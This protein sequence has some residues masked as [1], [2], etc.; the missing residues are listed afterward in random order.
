L[1]A[2]LTMLKSICKIVNIDDMYYHDRGKG[3]TRP[4]V[5]E[6][7]PHRQNPNCLDSN[8]NL[9]LGL[10]WGLT[11][12]LIDGRNVTLTSTNSETDEFLVRSEFS[13]AIA[14]QGSLVVSGHEEL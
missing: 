4:L 7:A 1:S 6:G 5:R 9:V 12:R 10:R 3:Q 2:L 13:P 11:P 14:I 8:I